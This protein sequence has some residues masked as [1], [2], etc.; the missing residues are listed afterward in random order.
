MAA[1]QPTER[2]LPYELSSELFSDYA[3]KQRLLR[4]PDLVNADRSDHDAAIEV[5]TMGRYTHPGCSG[6]RGQCPGTR[7]P[8]TRQPSIPG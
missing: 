8:M 2:V 1:L 3:S 5:I 4:I 6:R 7:T